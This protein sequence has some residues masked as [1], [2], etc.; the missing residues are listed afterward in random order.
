M[1]QSGNQAN[2]IVEIF[3]MGDTN[4]PRLSGKEYA[5]AM[6]WDLSKMCGPILLNFGKKNGLKKCKNIDCPNP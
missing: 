2:Y 5:T 3:C 6:A 1:F 4:G